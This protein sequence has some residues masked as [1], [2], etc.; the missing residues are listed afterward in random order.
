MNKHN[1]NP[2]K[3]YALISDNNKYVSVEYNP[4]DDLMY[5]EEIDEVNYNNYFFAYFI[6]YNVAKHTMTDINERDKDYQIEG[7]LSIANIAEVMIELSMTV[8]NFINN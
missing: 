1:E 4:V 5:V 8:K 3:Y 7:D 6:D 2:P